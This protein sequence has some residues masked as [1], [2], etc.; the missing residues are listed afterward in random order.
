MLPFTKVFAV[1]VYEIHRLF[2]QVWSVSNPAAST[3]PVPHKRSPTFTPHTKR[4]PMCQQ[5]YR[6]G[7]ALIS[8]IVFLFV[9]SVKVGGP[10]CGT[11]CFVSNVTINERNSITQIQGRFEQIVR[12]FGK[13]PGRA[14]IGRPS[15]LLSLHRCRQQSLLDRSWNLGWENEHYIQCRHV[16]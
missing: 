3:H 2:I 4:A 8:H 14:D 5:Q 9:G 10:L 16:Y 11:C 7:Q 1:Y 13:T 6:W 15:A 12:R